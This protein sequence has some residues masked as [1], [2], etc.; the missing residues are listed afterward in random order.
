MLVGHLGAG[1]A[2]KAVAPRIGLGTLVAASLLL[3]IVLWLLVILHIEGATVP[4]DFADR[5]ALAFSF[6]W[7]HSLVGAVFW[8]A[9]AAFIWT[10]S[11]GAGRY[12]AFAPAVIAATVLSHWALDFLV[13]P[14][15]MPLWPGSPA[16]GLGLTQPTALIVELAIAALGFGVFLLR[17]RLSLARRAVIAGLTLAVAALSAIGAAGTAPPGDIL[18]LAGIS[19]LVLF[20]IIATAAIADR[21]AR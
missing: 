9:A 11:G 2:A 5:H 21:E 10:W 18:N 14:A 8:A 7:S 12:F 13:H 1:L 16:I 3:D 20:V 17:S 15:E 4:G 19:L 6:P